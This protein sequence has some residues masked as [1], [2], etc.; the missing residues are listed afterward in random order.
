MGR[1][2]T[3]HPRKILREEF[4]ASSNMSARALALAI[5]PNRITSILNEDR[6][7][8]ADTAIRLGLYFGTSSEFWLNLQ[9]EHDLSNAENDG[10]FHKVK[11]REVEHA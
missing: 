7:V 8:T 6:A 4:L 9:Q 1:R 10:D 11:R 2:I 5:A 3:T